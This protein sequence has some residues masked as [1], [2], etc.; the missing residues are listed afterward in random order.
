MRTV[1]Q[2]LVTF[3]P[4]GHNWDRHNGGGGDGKCLSNLAGVG[5]TC[6]KVIQYWKASGIFN[7][8]ILSREEGIKKL[9][10]GM[11]DRC[12]WKQVYD[13]NRLAMEKVRG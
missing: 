12:Q 1:S 9:K 7:Y 11:I 6:R 10:E 13:D 8:G 4:S 2:P 5:V 3:G